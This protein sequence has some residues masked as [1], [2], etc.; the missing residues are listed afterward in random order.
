MLIGC[1]LYRQVDSMALVYGV[2]N[3]ADVVGGL[4]P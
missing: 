3:E 1:R 4:Q 2:S